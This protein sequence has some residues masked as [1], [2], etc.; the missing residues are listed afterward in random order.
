MKNLTFDFSNFTALVTGGASGMASA[1]TKSDPPVLTRTGPTKCAV[2][3][4]VV[5]ANDGRGTVALAQQT[6]VDM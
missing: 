6:R 5:R 3:G 4:G 2:V 1:L